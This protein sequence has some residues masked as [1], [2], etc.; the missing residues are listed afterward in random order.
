MAPAQVS[1][2]IST[3][4][5]GNPIRSSIDSIL[6][7]RGVAFEIIVVDSSDDDAT[8]DA[9]HKYITR[10]EV[11]YF[12]IAHR[13]LSVSRNFGVRQ[14]ASDII[15]LTDDDCEAAPG[16]LAKITEPLSA[17]PRVAVAFGNVVAPLTNPAEC[18]AISYTRHGSYLA[19]SLAQ[20]HR[21]EGIGGC[22]ALRREVWQKLGGFDALLGVGARFHAAE[23]VDLTL[24]SLRAGYS[25][26]ETDEAEV[27]HTGIRP[28]A[29][30]NAIARKYAFGIAAVYAKHLRCG[31]LSVL[32]PLVALAAR[33][34]FGKPAVSYGRPPSHWSRLAGFVQGFFAACLPPLNRD[35]AIFTEPMSDP[36]S[37]FADKQHADWLRYL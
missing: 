7:Q 30:K 5:R 13:G 29:S 16:W 34:A 14:A 19:S 2:V 31:R 37:P 21:V 11:R 36:S 9:L 25:V 3:R 23:E 20:K 27:L 4:G 32:I 22:M 33:W 12:R 6:G 10:G 28:N 17:D 1:V 24:R 18:F 8:L 26:F 35:R 15:A